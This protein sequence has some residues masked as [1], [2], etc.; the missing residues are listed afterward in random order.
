VNDLPIQ[1]LM[2]RELSTVEVSTPLTEVVAAANERRLSCLVVT[3]G[4]RPVGIITE[5]DLVATLAQV[6][7]GAEFTQR[8]AAEIMSQPP[9]TIHERAALFEALVVA[10]SRNIR[11]LP[12]VDD[13]GRFVGLITQSNLVAAHFRLV[14]RQREALEQTVQERTAELAEANEM[15]KALSLTDT[16]LGIGNRRAMEVDLEHTLAEANRYGGPCSLALLDVDYF[17]R[18]NDHYGHQAGDEALRVLVAYLRQH[19][20]GADRLYRYGGEELLLLM[21]KADREQATQTVSRLVQ[22]LA[23]ESIPHE[24][25]PL[26]KLTI[27]AGVATQ[28]AGGPSSVRSL[29]GCADRNLYQAKADGRNRMIAPDCSKAA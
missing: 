5:R 15:L 9:I 7:G 12:V 6:M 4:E 14:D 17:K 27:S 13:S 20:R 23:R 8:T 11:H 22:G 21:P 2:T 19:V 1:E 16:L 25:S 3:E 10:R 26:G 29:L 28:S 24:G 18:Y